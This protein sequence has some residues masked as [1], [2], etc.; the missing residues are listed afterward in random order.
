MAPR[1]LVEEIEGGDQLPSVDLAVGV[2]VH[3]REQ[4]SKRF[5]PLGFLEAEGLVFV[6]VE[7]LPLGVKLLACA[8]ELGLPVLGAE[9]DPD[10]AHLERQRGFSGHP[11][12]CR[13][14]VRAP[15]VLV[16]AAD[17]LDGR[18]FRGGPAQPD[19]HLE[20]RVSPVEELHQLVAVERLVAVSVEGREDLGP[21]AE[22]RA[23]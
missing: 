8:I 6:L 3:E 10:V 11:D 15:L 14:P 18:R 9:L 1:Q 4:A 16:L 2:A 12:P 13:G 21:Q 22:L 20:C 7:G 5:L 19:D 17:D 23:A